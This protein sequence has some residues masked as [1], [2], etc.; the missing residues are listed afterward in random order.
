MFQEIDRNKRNEREKYSNVWP[1]RIKK[2]VAEGNM[3]IFASRIVAEEML[4]SGG[5][6]G[7]Q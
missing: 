3:W 1:G 2:S 6:G 7:S 4:I 5:G